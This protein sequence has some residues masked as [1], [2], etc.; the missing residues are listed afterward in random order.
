MSQD[1]PAGRGYH[2]RVDGAEHIQWDVAIVGAGAAGVATAI[3]AAEAA[4]APCWTPCCD[5]ATP[6][7]SSSYEAT[8]SSMSPARANRP[9]QPASKS[10]PQVRHPCCTRGGL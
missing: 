6:W 8:A 9:S 1:V 5:D 10:R 4:P 2:S 7:T 3:F